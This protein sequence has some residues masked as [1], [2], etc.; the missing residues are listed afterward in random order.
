MKKFSCFLFVV[1]LSLQIHGQKKF[2]TAGVIG[3][4]SVTQV[5]GDAYGGFHKFG[6][7]LGARLYTPQI[8]SKR[9]GFDVVL[10]QKGSVSNFGDGQAGYLQYKIALLYAEVPFFIQ[11]QK[12]KLL[13]E[14]GGALGALLTSKEEDN[15]GEI[16]S[17][18]EFR[19]WELGF[20]AG[21]GIQATK[22]IQILF[23]YNY[24]L[25]P[26]RVLINNASLYDYSAGQYNHGLSGKLIFLL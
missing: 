16:N 12:N 21:F 1:F 4:L 24:S 7:I 2:F 22:K 13:Y 9:F 17:S 19:P 3:G 14:V 23:H 20:I 6:A 15:F 11:F 26:V 25:L 10:T 5:D 18:K 8:R